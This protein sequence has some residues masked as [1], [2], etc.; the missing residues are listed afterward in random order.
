[1]KVSLVM[2][3]A[4][5]LRTND[6]SYR[7]ALTASDCDSNTEQFVSAHQI[8]LHPE[9]NSFSCTRSPV[10]DLPSGGRCT[11][12]L[13]GVSIC[14]PDEYSCS[15]PPRVSDDDCT[16]RQDRVASRKHVLS[17]PVKYPA[18]VLDTYEVVCIYDASE[19]QSIMDPWQSFAFVPAKDV[20][21]DTTGGYCEC[22]QVATGACVYEFQKYVCAIGP[23][24][25]DS[26]AEYMTAMDLHLVK[27]EW[28]C[29]L[30]REE[31]GS[32]QWGQLW[33]FIAVGTVSILLRCVAVNLLHCFRRVFGV[34]HKAEIRDSDGINTIELQ[35]QTSAEMT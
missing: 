19:C 13:S 24:A 29:R 17:V 5:V 15:N 3:G 1:M 32:N 23:E 10:D 31:N 34:Y 4:C 16:V 6:S 12:A 11:S 20:A 9:W 2:A 25:C 33:L 30:C 14:T 22:D 8:Q 7:C 27:P 18:C 21:M 35:S 28:K 26:G